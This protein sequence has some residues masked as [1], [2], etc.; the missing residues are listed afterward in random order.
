MAIDNMA[1]R[2]YSEDSAFGKAR[3]VY[4]AGGSVGWVRA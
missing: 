2:A 4:N 3:L 1:S